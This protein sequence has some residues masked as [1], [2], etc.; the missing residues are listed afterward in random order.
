[1][2]E[3]GGINHQQ[4]AIGRAR[5]GARGEKDLETG[6]EREKG[7]KQLWCTLESLPD[8][9]LRLQSGPA[10]AADDVLQTTYCCNASWSSM[11]L[12]TGSPHTS[13]EHCPAGTAVL[14]TKQLRNFL[15]SPKPPLPP[16]CEFLFCSIKD[17]N[18]EKCGPEQALIKRALMVSQVPEV[19]KGFNI[20]D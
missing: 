15:Y 13:P 11:A 2:A 10:A 9:G 8:F 18:F 12:L 20:R 19:I 16:N 3:P 14:Q 5:S 6:R 1:M 7:R 17:F 4:I